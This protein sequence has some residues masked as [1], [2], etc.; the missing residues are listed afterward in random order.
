MDS[1]AYDTRRVRTT[2]TWIAGVVALSVALLMPLVYYTLSYQYL[3]GGME[4]EAEVTAA[5]VT[6][7]INA[8][9]D[10]W[11]FEQ[12]R[13]EELLSQRRQIDHTE[14][15][16]VYDLE[17][18]LLAQNRSSLNPPL[19]SRRT[20]LLESGKPAGSLEIQASLLP[21]LVNSSM[22]TLFSLFCGFVVFSALR[23][24][25]LRAVALAEASL[26]ESEQRY[27]DLVDN[28]PDAILVYGRETILYAN[29]AAQGLFRAHSV[30]QLVGQP[31]STICKSDKHDLEGTCLRMNGQGGQAASRMEMRLMRLDGSWIDVVV[32]GI[33]TEF[34]GES[35]VQVILHDVSEKKKLIDELQDKIILLEAARANIKQLEGIIPICMYCKNIRDDKESWQQL[36]SYISEHSE[37]LFSHGICPEC[38]PKVKSQALKELG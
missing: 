37:A 22:A 28:A 23:T 17:G 18:V 7:L 11:K 38:F 15:R 25:P 5:F 20:T 24:L 10:L 30:N 6:R 36:E 3:I 19:I 21:L 2:T 31:V 14:V 4:A 27:R 12:S 32:V 29:R 34:R 1:T 9:P 8:N 26:R 13:M 16:R 35:A 33:T